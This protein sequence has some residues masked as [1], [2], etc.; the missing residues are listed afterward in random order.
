MRRIAGKGIDAVTLVHKLVAVVWVVGALGVLVLAVPVTHYAA[1]DSS[2]TWARIV[3]FQDVAS[4]S[5]VAMLLVGLVYGVWTT[6]GFLRN[7][8]VILKW[9]LF[10]AATGFGGP[11][12]SAARS[13]SATGV[14]V[15]TALEL[16]VLVAA[17]AVGVYLER[18][19]HSGRLSVK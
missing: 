15:L 1:S 9:V 10:L 5:S 3:G 6:W 19:R 2:V 7:R 8:L 13:H 18:S 4:A 17:G 12:I 16:V 14:I 11:S